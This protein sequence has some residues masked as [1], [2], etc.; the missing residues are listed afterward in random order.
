MT[1]GW[2]HNTMFP[3]NYLEVGHHSPI[4]IINWKY[5]S[6]LILALKISPLYPSVF[7]AITLAKH[8]SIHTVSLPPSVQGPATSATPPPRT[9]V[10]VNVYIFLSIVSVFLTHL[11]KGISWSVCVLFVSHFQCFILRPCANSVYEVQF[12]KDN[13]IIVHYLH[14]YAYLFCEA[15][16][17]W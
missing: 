6:L 1:T 5:C 15:A 4:S 7:C 12:R 11:S 2:R 16:I 10:C 13:Q 9:K 17:L 8:L 14:S 3:I